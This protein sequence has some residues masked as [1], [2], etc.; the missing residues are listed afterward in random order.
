[1]AELAQIPLIVAALNSTENESLSNYF[2]ARVTSRPPLPRDLLVIS[3]YALQP[4]I[5][6]LHK[7][8]Y[9]RKLLLCT[10]SVSLFF[11]QRHFR[12][13]GM[14]FVCY[15][16]ISPLFSSSK[17]K[18]G[19]GRHGIGEREREDGTLPLHR[20]ATATIS[21][22]VITDRFHTTRLQDGMASICA[23]ASRNQAV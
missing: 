3:H 1:M 18:I 8:P 22:C 12:L 21:P 17:S 19:I 5:R 9:L 20:E 10:H 4:L 16:N 6:A 13:L 14:L 11:P 23:I 15:D 2:F 7:S